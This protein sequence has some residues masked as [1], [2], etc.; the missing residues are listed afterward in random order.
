M[1]SSFSSQK[2]NNKLKIRWA[3]SGVNTQLVSWWNAKFIVKTTCFGLCTGPS[4][5]FDVYQKENYTACSSSDT[6]RDLMMAQCKG[7]RNNKFSTPPP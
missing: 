6:R 2:G 4:S 5:G 1:F 3:V 7:L